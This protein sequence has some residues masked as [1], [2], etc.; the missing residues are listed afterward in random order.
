MLVRLHPHALA[1]VAHTA[2]AV[3]TAA[4]IHLI[5]LFIGSSAQVSEIPSL[6]LLP[7]KQKYRAAIA[8]APPSEPRVSPHSTSTLE[9]ITL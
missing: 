3:A 5:D 8:T 9:E 6:P 4:A 7:A 1:S 2:D